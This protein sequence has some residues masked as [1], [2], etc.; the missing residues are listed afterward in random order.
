M[1]TADRGQPL[2]A[3]RVVDLSSGVAGGYATKLLADFG[4]D[5]IKVEPPGGDPLRGWGAFAGEDAGEPSPPGEPTHAGEPAEPAEPAQRAQPGERTGTRAAAPPPETATLHLHLGTN[6]R[7][8]VADLDT[9]DGRA[10]VAALAATA[11]VVVESFPPGYLAARRLGWGDLSAANPGL[12]M[13]SVTPFGQD[14]P[15]AS[16]RGSEIVAYAMGGPMHATGIAEREPLKLGGHEVSYQCG[17]VVALATLAA[18]TTAEA[19]GQGI[20]IDISNFETQAASIDRRAV[21]AVQHAYNGKVMGRDARGAEGL[22]PIGLYPAA[23][24]YVSIGTPPIFAGRLQSTLA[25][26]ELDELFAD[27]AWMTNPDVPGLVAAKV[28]GWLAERTTAQAMADAQPHHWPVTALRAPIDVLDDEH[29]RARGYW[30]Q[31][32]HPL[33]GTVT[34]PGPPVRLDGAWSLRRPAPLL[35]QHGDEIRA[36]LARASTAS[37]TS[38]AHPAPPR[39][40]LEGVRVLDLTVVW[41]GP[42]TTMLL[43]DLGA[44]VIRVENPFHYNGT[45]GASPRP[46]PAQLPALG[47]L[48]AHPDNEPGER[49]WNRNAFF[50]CHARNKAGAS[51]DLRRPE[52]V[53]AFLRLV[54]QSDVV[55]E[56][57]SVDVLDHLGIGWDVLSSRNP[58]LVLLRMPALGLSGPHAKYIGFG[59]NFEALC[60]LTALRGYP[61]EDPS[62]THSVYYMD[63]AS[64][65]IGA[66]SVLLA[67]R[68]RHADPQHRGELIELAQSEN[69]VH[70]IGE[71]VLD[72]ALHGR[73]HGPAANRD[74]AVAPQGAYPCAGHDRWLAL[75]VFD[76]ADW[77]ALRATMGDPG[78]A[79]DERLATAAGRRRHHDEL[80]ARLAEW[81]VTRD[82][83]ELAAELQAAGMAAGPVLDDAE[84]LADAHLGHRGFFRENGSPEVGRH[85]YPGHLWRWTG[86]P[87][88]WLPLCRFGADNNHVWRDVAGLDEASIAQLE[89]D[90][91]LTTEFF[92]PTGA[93]L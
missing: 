15:Y 41:A 22:L 54:E 63:A 40:P 50:N 51:I 76:D 53:E 48:N 84:V 27:P 75:T 35:D 34:H 5:V 52:G 36:E 93:K 78:W 81:T 32:E 29:L 91:H 65:V 86:P 38:P 30:R 8:V 14:G 80:D 61:D 66:T 64:G 55:V 85:R 60:G 13:A 16:W 39:L 43:G 19:S 12:V 17:G 72:A 24:G 88:A 71:Y 92:S 79:A 74:I 90:G 31:L 59:S 42:Y 67:L 6:K 20:H 7:S 58:G 49:P 56:N 68:R 10:L 21:F 28:Y 89:R 26:P 11:Q 46:Q 4:A 37:P 45:R 73:R 18:L 47:W 25:D 23:D 62:T 69:M 82:R 2:T 87:L 3:V 77:L 33:A 83:D 44:E 70:H 57:N 1:T 9:A